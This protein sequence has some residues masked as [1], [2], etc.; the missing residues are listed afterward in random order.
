MRVVFRPNKSNIESIPHSIYMYVYGH[1]TL[2]MDGYVFLNLTDG[3][4]AFVC[5][6]WARCSKAPADAF[7]LCSLKIVRIHIRHKCM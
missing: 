2:S 6:I 5:C 1:Q 3:C 4:D 7:Q